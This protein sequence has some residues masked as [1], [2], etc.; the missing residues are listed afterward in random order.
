MGDIPP[1]LC[2]IIAIV[3]WI[4][5]NCTKSYLTAANGSAA[6]LITYVPD[7]ETETPPAVND[8]QW[9]LDDGGRWKSES[10]FPVYAIPGASGS[11]I[12][13]QLANYNGNAESVEN[14][15]FRGVASDPNDL[16]RLWTSIQLN[17]QNNLPSLWAFLLM[18]L[19]IVL[20]LVAL[21]SFAMHVYQ[22]QA[23]R[24]LRRRVVRGDVDLEALGIRRINVPQELLG[25][26]P[27]YVYTSAAT[28]SP[29]QKSPITTQLPRRNSEPVPILPGV[30]SGTNP[31]TA[32][33]SFKQ[34]TCAICLDDFVHNSTTVKELP[35]RHIYHPQCIDELLRIHSCLCPVC[36]AKV[37]PNGYCPETI[38]NA[39][40]R[41]ERQARRHPHPEPNSQDPV[42]ATLTSETRRGPLAVGGRMASFHRQFG[43]TSRS[44]G[45]SRISSAPEPQSVEMMN[46]PAP[47]ATSITALAAPAST[48]QPPI[49]R[50]E[51]ARRRVSAL[52]GHQ[53]M[54][55]DEESE[56]RQHL[57]KC[58]SAPTPQSNDFLIL[59]GRK[60][61]GSVFPGFR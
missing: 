26:L 11:A 42:G 38:T 17:G 25:K 33:P 43:R 32:S 30:S 56:R 59:L 21:T 15:S 55:V 47:A 46:R 53:V 22:R 48:L 34:P 51:R 39:M 36:K 18:V 20:V 40:V 16:I 44:R 35:C 6:A 58:K 50:A 28:E 2:N 3:P 23:R 4:S 37:L 7:D 61:V 41:R 1:D 45:Q 27:V 10:Q 24:S 57:P 49:D 5:S 29:S 31:P 19:G 14:G 13:Q 54:A 9:F 8:Q 60:A 52:L 12:M